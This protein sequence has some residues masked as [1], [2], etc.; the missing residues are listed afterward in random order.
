MKSLDFG[1]IK[2]AISLIVTVIALSVTAHLLSESLQDQHKLVQSSLL[3]KKQTLHNKKLENDEKRR[4]YKAYS[5]SYAA[6]QVAGVYSDN[7]RLNWIEEIEHA[8]NVLQLPMTQYEIE[9]RVRQDIPA[10]SQTGTLGF[11][12]AAINI[13]FELYHEGDLLRILDYLSSSQLGLYEVD[14]CA[15]TRQETHSSEQKE[16]QK[17]T[18]LLQAECKLQS[19]SFVFDD[20]QTAAPGIN[21]QII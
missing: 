2:Y 16:D 17:N 8:A 15:L 12:S 4:I 10:P 19:Y 1:L 7:A 6:L 18:V 13:N 20:M 3:A 9:P 21:D 5:K 14:S 11:Y